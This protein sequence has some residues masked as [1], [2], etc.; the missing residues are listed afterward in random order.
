[1]S[2]PVFVAFDTETSG[3]WPISSEIVEFGAVKFNT[4][5][6]F[7]DEINFLI[8]PSKP[9]EEA[10]IKIHGITNEMLANQ[11]SLSEVIQPIY[12]FMN[13]NI[14]V[15]HHA[16]FDLGFVSLAFEKHNLQFTQWPQALCSSLLARRLIAEST[17]H[18]LQ[19]LVKLL[20]IDGGHAHRA[21]DDAKACAQVFL[22]C[23]RRAAPSNSLTDLHRFQGKNLDWKNYG[24]FNF[25]SSKLKDFA[26]AIEAGRIVDMVYEGGSM[27][28]KTRQVRP[29]G[30]V[31][32]PDGDYLYA[33]CLIDHTNKRFFFD[34]IQD[35]AVRSQ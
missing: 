23:Y 15:A 12:Q 2:D 16:P 17:N 5:G 13:H 3:A 14:C 26:Q 29:I 27:S 30:V 21:L 24:V 4:K 6:E 35:Y 28:G 1:M 31:R 11:P 8:K 10:N 7:L 9:L 18:K 19:T 34:K 20:K 25:G 32:N 33:E 22:E